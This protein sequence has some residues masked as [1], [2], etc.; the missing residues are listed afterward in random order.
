MNKYKIKILAYLISVSTFLTSCGLIDAPIDKIEDE[1]TL[2][3]PTTS[4]GTTIET[5]PPVVETK[6]EETT[7]STNP[8]IEEIKPEE[9][10]PVIEETQPVVQAS[11]N[12]V[13]YATTNVNFRAS[14]SADSMKIGNLNIGDE[15]YRILSCDNN[16]DLVRY[17]GKLGFVCRDYLEY[18]NEYVDSS[19]EHMPK[20]DI[21]LTNTDLNF[22]TAPTTDADR[23][24]TFDKGTELQ[25]LAEVD[26]GWLLVRHN[27]ELGYV[28]GE[29]TTSLLEKVNYLYPEL[30]LDELVVE[31]VIYNAS[32]ELNL[33]EGE[34][35]DT[36]IKDSL[37]QYETARVLKETDD[38]YL[39][40][41]NDY[42][43]GYLYKDYTKEMTG[44]FVDIDKS[45]Q[46]MTLYNGNEVMVQTPVTTGKDSTPS[47]TG[48]FDIDNKV[49]KTYLMNNSY[50]EYWMPY[51]G[52][53]GIHDA[54][55][56]EDW[57]FGT[58]IYHI[59]GSH[60]CINTPLEEVIQIYDNVEIGT[61]V[62][63]HK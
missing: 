49:R 53:E 51:N 36:E 55:W 41:T 4:V 18:T 7:P 14:N 17:N 34:G 57:E 3:K 50:V 39:V 42:E 38:W 9:S 12:M 10:K 5:K 47:D 8:T 22:R 56:R 24:D 52:G 33:R 35:T 15:A 61:K 25:V 40:M 13:V 19:Y 54:G 16:W 6:P 44:I 37:T 27:G 26:N 59:S 29:Y 43:F 1:L 23:L 46:R 31:K 60:G 32:T 20:N 48:Y 30:E 63:V 62:L 2:Q 11:D 21:V 45:E 28:S 58:D